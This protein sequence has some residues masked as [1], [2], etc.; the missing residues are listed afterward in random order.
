MTLANT[1]YQL[2]TTE[3]NCRSVT[4]TLYSDANFTPSTTTVLKIRLGSATA[5]GVVMQAAFGNSYPISVTVPDWGPHEIWVE[6]DQ[7]GDTISYICAQ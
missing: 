3:R 2:S 7:A 1:P 6:S 5:G 4:V